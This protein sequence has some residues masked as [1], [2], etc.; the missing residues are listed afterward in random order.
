[1]TPIS[2]TLSQEEHAVEMNVDLGS[3]EGI[4]D[5]NRLDSIQEPHPDSRVNETI[6]MHQSEVRSNLNYFPLTMT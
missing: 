2:C 6:S 1:M 4:I 5:E 3:G